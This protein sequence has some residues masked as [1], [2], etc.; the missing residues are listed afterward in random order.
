[1][2]DRRNEDGVYEFME[3]S[4]GTPHARDYKRADDELERQKTIL[5]TARSTVQSAIDG[6][7]SE[8]LAN[9]R[10]KSSYEALG[11]TDAPYSHGEN[12]IDGVYKNPHGPPDYI[13][14]EVKHG[15]QLPKTLADGSKQASDDWV[16][17]RLD[18]HFAGEPGNTAADIKS[19]LGTDKVQKWLIQVDDHGRV[20]KHQLDKDANLI[21]GTMVN[22]LGIGG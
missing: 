22:H 3:P 13:I 17:D 19:K 21:P 11:K 6:A 9:S 15:N 7:Y 10:M 1:Y 18:G 5:Q 12:G 16:R 2:K 20:T 8:D 14:T 4:H